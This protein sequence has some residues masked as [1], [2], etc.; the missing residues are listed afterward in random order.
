VPRLFALEN[1]SLS[2]AYVAIDTASDHRFALTFEPLRPR[3]AVRDPLLQHD[4]ATLI[5]AIETKG[6]ARYST[7]LFE[8]QESLASYCEIFTEFESAYVLAFDYGYTISEIENYPRGTLMAYARHVATEDVLTDCGARDITCHVNFSLLET[9][10]E[11]AG[12][13]EQAR[14]SQSSWLLEHGLLDFVEAA[15][16]DRKREAL[17]DFKSL[18]I[19]GTMSKTF[20]ALEAWKG[21]NR[22]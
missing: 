12:F 2:E 20:T 16:P 21:C 6:L 17:N 14:A 19:P 10:L 11:R 22:S 9:W 4:L 1:R 5:G 8:F 18:V 13:S 15:A 3:D 7:F